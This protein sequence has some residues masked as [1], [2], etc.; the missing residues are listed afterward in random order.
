M[1]LCGVNPKVVFCLKNGRVIFFKNAM[2]FDGLYRLFVFP[3]FGW[4]FACLLCVLIDLCYDMWKPWIGMVD[5]FRIVEHPR[6]FDF[7]HC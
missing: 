6:A 5:M 7:S 3:V 4:Y 2:T 1:V